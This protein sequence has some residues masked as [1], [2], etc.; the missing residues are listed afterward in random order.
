M[1]RQPICQQIWKTQQQPQDCKRSVF[2]PIPKTQS[3]SVMSDSV[4]PWTVAHPVPL[5]ME[6][7]R[8]EY[9][10]GLPCPSPGDL[11]DPGIEPTS[12]MS[13]ALESDSLPLSHQESPL[14]CLLS[15]YFPISSSLCFPI[16]L[17]FLFMF[18]LKTF[19]SII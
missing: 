9:Q 4:T 16:S 10:S 1:V 5:S 18:F 7:C 3:C 15:R 13:L 8:Q 17:I 12:P 2:I 19:S 6:F 11:L 14:E